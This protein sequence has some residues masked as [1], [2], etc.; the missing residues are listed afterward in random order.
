MCY[1]IALAME[2]HRLSP[3]VNVHSHLQQFNQFLT[4]Y[5]E[6]LGAGMV[7]ARE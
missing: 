6:R 7:T 4:A 2:V 3:A 1:L 5:N